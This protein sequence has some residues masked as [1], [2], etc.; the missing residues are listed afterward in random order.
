M[1]HSLENPV[2]SNTKKKKKS[3][4]QELEIFNKER[5]ASAGS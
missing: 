3:K 4:C 5:E 1:E 2:H